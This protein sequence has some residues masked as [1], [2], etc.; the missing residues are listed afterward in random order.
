[1][2]LAFHIGCHKTGTTWLQ[3]TYFNH[4]PD[5]Q[6]LA[7][8]SKPWDNPFLRYLVATLIGYLIHA[9]ALSY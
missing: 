2:N 1:M 9:I 7:D 8:P 4:H 3:Q 5:I 6:L